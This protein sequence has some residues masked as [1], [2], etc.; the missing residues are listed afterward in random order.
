MQ[1]KINIE[2]LS[3]EK[4]IIHVTDT[5]GRRTSKMVTAR[6]AAAALAGPNLE[7]KDSGLIPPEILRTWENSEYK[8]YLVYQAPRNFVLNYEEK[9][10]FPVKLPGIVMKIVANRHGC[11]R[12]KSSIF[13]CDGENIRPDTKLWHLRMNNYS[14]SYGICWGQNETLANDIL[15]SGNLFDIAQL[16][17][18]FFGSTFNSD[19]ND[20]YDFVSRAVDAMSGI[21]T[22]ILNM[23]YTAR[24]FHMKHEKN[25]DF[26]IADEITNSSSIKLAGIV[27]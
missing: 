17:A 5:E 8:G 22:P 27:L 18:L 16:P 19:L 26:N 24:Y 11:V 6:A 2:V 12:Q 10:S 20:S 15:K 23:N 4:V 7:E 1:G 14:S 9:G 25:E 21:R 3:Q 13:I